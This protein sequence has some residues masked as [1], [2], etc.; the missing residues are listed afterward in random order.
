[1]IARVFQ[2]LV[3]SFILFLSLLINQRIQSDI[4][5][6]PQKNLSAQH[7]Q[8]TTTVDAS[9]NS[10]TYFGQMIKN[11]TD[12]SY[13]NTQELTLTL[14]E[15]KHCITFNWKFGGSGNIFLPL[16]SV[17]A[18]Y[19][20]KTDS[21]ESPT[22]EKS[23]AQNML[24]ELGKAF[25]KNELNKKSKHVTLL[26]WLTQTK[27]SPLH[28][29]VIK[30]LLLFKDTHPIN[31]A[32]FIKSEL[33]RL[34][35]RLSLVEDIHLF[36]T[37]K[38]LSAH[39]PEVLTEGLAL[40]A[41]DTLFYLDNVWRIMKT[42]SLST[43]NQDT[44]LSSTYFQIKAYAFYAQ[45]KAEQCYTSWQKS[46]FTNDIHSIIFKNG[47]ELVPSYHEFTTIHPSSKNNLASFLVSELSLAGDIKDEY[48]TSLFPTLP[49]IF[50]ENADKRTFLLEGN[51]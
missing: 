23:A 48:V 30:V 28:L 36:D 17:T 47:L 41:P 40:V 39:L 27:L 4:G 43:E 21:E 12:L 26:K 22:P 16:P 50:K 2:S 15:T 1:M 49:I 7:T 20:K 44:Y 14:P 9:H 31:D 10:M 13:S 45:N 34:L 46:N 35:F 18:Q 6:Q 32:S 25:L 33:C 24:A 3:F 42:S 5:F 37:K 19:L 51:E 8:N 11:F 38:P 29:F